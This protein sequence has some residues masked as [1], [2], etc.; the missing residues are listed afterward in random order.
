M[1]SA[2]KWSSLVR[3]AGWAALIP[4]AYYFGW[5]AS[6]TFVAICSLYANLASD[7]AAWR[8]DDNPQLERIERLLNELKE[9]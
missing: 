4:I 9:K 5:L 7:F 3:A 2:L 8:A 1:E 6:V